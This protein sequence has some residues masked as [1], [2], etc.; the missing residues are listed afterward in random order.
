MDEATLA[1]SDKVL[2]FSVWSFW[3]PALRVA[4]A[5]FAINWHKWKL[6]KGFNNS[7][8]SHWF[9]YYSTEKGMQLNL[10]NSRTFVTL[11]EALADSGRLRGFIPRPEMRKIVAEKWCNFLKLYFYQQIFQN[12]VKNSI[13]LFKY[14]QKF[15]QNII[16]LLVCPTI[17]NLTSGF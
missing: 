7:H 6:C 17:E 13:C 5:N 11:G 8:N 16:L 15:T 3:P 4:H 14:H 9:W 1:L 12:Q 2:N 10:E